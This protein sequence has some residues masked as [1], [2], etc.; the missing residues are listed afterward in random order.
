M[1]R[2]RPASPDLYDTVAQLRSDLSAA[3]TRIAVLESQQ[4]DTVTAR[5]EIRS[6]L[7]DLGDIVE[8]IRQNAE[9]TARRR[10]QRGGPA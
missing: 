1:A 9:S 5:A 8:R 10:T 2:R 6:Q 3:I 7:S 4:Q